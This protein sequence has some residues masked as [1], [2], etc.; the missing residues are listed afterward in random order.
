MR[1]DHAHLARVVRLV[2]LELD[3]VERVPGRAAVDLEQQPVELSP[4]ATPLGPVVELLDSSHHASERETK[5]GRLPT[6]AVVDSREHLRRLVVT[7]ET[8]R[9]GPPGQLGAQRGVA[10]GGLD[11]RVLRGHAV[12][13]AAVDRLLRRPQGGE[14]LTPLAD[15]GELR[16]HH[17]V[18][19]ASATMRGK[20]ADDRDA[21]ARHL[22]AGNTQLE[23]ERAGAADDRGAVERGV[24]ALEG[25][26]APEPLERPRLSSHRRSSGRWR[27]ARRRTRPDCELFER[28]APSV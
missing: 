7:D 2:E 9:A 21:C 12:S 25:K 28:E 10:A 11:H 23:R 24:H 8:G 16:P 20:D 19:D 17:A 15:V 3:A 4:A 1:L 22:R 6:D 5:P 26:Q 18:E 14:R 13:E 27:R